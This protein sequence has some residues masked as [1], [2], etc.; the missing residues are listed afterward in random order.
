MTSIRDNYNSCSLTR[1][2]IT[3]GIIN[4][5]NEL[6]VIELEGWEDINFRKIKFIVRNRRL[7]DKTLLLLL[8]DLN[9]LKDNEDKLW[10]EDSIDSELEF[11]DDSFHKGIL[12]DPLLIINKYKNG[13]LN[14][15]KIHKDIYV[16]NDE[17]R[18]KLPDSLKK[19]LPEWKSES[20]DTIYRKVKNLLPGLKGQEGSQ[21]RIFIAE[22][23]EYIYYRDQFLEEENEDVYDL[24]KDDQIA[25]L[26]LFRVET[27]ILPHIEVIEKYEESGGNIIYSNIWELP[28]TEALKQE[29]RERD[30]FKCVICEADVNLHV[31]HKIPRNLG[32][33]H[34]RD[35]LVTLCASCHGAVERADTKKAFIKCLA[36]YRKTKA[37][38][39][40][41][42]D[43]PVNKTKLKIQVDEKLNLLL[44]EL[45]NK[46]ED[47]AREV[48]EIM[49]RLEVLFN[50]E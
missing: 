25:E 7:S 15:N 24:T 8:K 50:M 22:L 14:V 19:F 46:N 49:S 43:L 47:L 48:V 29:V 37:L 5:V 30:N 21:C 12:I 44:N 4:L 42:S 17:W 33:V 45:S 10:N 34:H 1:T 13:N 18:T 2:Q 32:G 23:S 16:E 36:N 9:Q 3:D 41:N 11:K 20:L 38:K 40:I 26:I 31:H 39:T 28:F 6:G 27:I 35:N